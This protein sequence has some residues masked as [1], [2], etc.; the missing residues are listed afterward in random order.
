MKSG[1]RLLAASLVITAVFPCA[2]DTSPLFVPVR[3]PEKFDTAFLRGELGIIPATL[4][5]KY[6]LIAWRYL[7]GLP[8]DGQEQAAILNV[9]NQTDHASYDATNA[10]EAA[11][12]SAGLAEIFFLRGKASRLDKGTYYENCLPDAFAVAAH[13]LNDRQ[14]RYADSK[15]L[16]AWIAAQD[17]VFQNCASDKP[18]YPD[19]PGPQLPPLAREDRLYQIAAAHFYAEDLTGAEQSFREIAADTSSPWHD[20]AAYLV[21]RTLIREVSLLHK[22]EA[23][24][25]AKAQLLTITAG[26]LYA[27]AQGLI[28]YVDAQTDPSAVLKS[29]SF[30]RPGSDFSSTF[31]E[32]TYV[33]TSDRFQSALAKPDLP[34]PFDWI[35]SFQPEKAGYALQRWQQ[36]RSTLWLTAALIQA[37]SGQKENAD[38]IE[39]ALKMPET[40]PA[41]DTVTMN[42]IRLM[43]A[44]GQRDT[45]RRKLDVLLSNKRHILDSVE[46]AYKGQRMSLAASFDDYLRWAPRRPIGITEEGYDPGD[47]DDSPVLGDEAVA[48]LNGLTP[49]SRLMEASQSR[50]LPPQSRTQAAI[51]AWTRAFMLQDDT[52][53]N[54]LSLQLA[55]AHTAWAPDLDAFRAA[56]GEEKRFAGA[57]LI[58]R[59]SDFHPDILIAFSPDWW[60][61]HGAPGAPDDSLPDAVLSPAE[62][63]RAANELRRVS[64]AGAT[65]NFLAPI[66]MSW[67]KAH[68]DDP[69]VAESLHRLVRITRYGCRD[70]S[71]N[72]DISRAAF[73]LLHRRYPASEWARQTPYW[74]N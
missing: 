27:S 7:S 60:C 25:Q 47:V 15:I 5:P 43:I 18:V 53:A 58:A 1:Y 14:K 39:A 52:T 9:Q 65:Q 17:Q 29:L 40:S 37:K 8:L 28:G 35:E 4:S 3:R 21:A 70:A 49:L 62:R 50:R 23:P 64:D 33:L 32:A 68:P 41:F 12:G 24:A 11:R 46:N 55:R 73:E 2:I 19:D 74:F 61:V 10:W 48:A 67:A 30:S 44:E 63:T 6:K 34:E 59:H 69:R 31:D 38:L 36:S 16:N 51:S 71:G 42:S 26:P 54:R 13:T 22:P 57:L 66:V 72:G 20:T 45:A 56:S